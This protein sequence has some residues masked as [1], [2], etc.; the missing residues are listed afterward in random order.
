L[1]GVKRLIERA[2]EEVATTDKTEGASRT[3][4]KEKMEEGPRKGKQEGG[5]KKKLC[6]KEA[7]R[8]L[9][10]TEGGGKNVKNSPQSRL[11]RPS[12]IDGS[13][14]LGRRLE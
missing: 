6:E 10:Q 14:T 5:T 13:V 12:F 11:G 3:R 9:S 7:V 4:K 8:P 2:L 1:F